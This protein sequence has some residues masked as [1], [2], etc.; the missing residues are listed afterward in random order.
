MGY[1]VEVEISPD[2]CA[3]LQ[4]CGACV[5]VCPVNIFEK[6][7]GM[8]GVVATNEDECILC[9]LCLDECAPGAI[10]IGKKY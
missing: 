2:K 9:D 5:K 4:E 7:G 6:R 3:G 1:F 8:P 10:T